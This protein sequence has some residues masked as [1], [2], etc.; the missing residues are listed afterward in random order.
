LGV[1]KFAKKTLYLRVVVSGN[2]IHGK[3]LLK[4]V[5]SFPGERWVLQNEPRD[6]VY[7]VARFVIRYV[8]DARGADEGVED[9]INF[10]A[11]CDEGLR[12]PQFGVVSVHPELLEEVEQKPRIDDIAAWID[13][14][15]A[16]E[17]HICGVLEQACNSLSLRKCS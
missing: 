5:D 4:I 12:C 1:A 3:P 8:R 6:N 11:A 13:S 16:I 2:S 9:G 17:D 10:E 7:E 15:R 14:P